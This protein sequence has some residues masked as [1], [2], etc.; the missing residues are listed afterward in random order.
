MKKLVSAINTSK[1]ETPNISILNGSDDIL[2]IDM[3]GHSDSS[4]L[5]ELINFHYIKTM[6]DF[7]KGAY[8]LMVLVVIPDPENKGEFILEDREIKMMA[9]F[10]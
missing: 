9:S 7:L 10:M 6:V 1:T 2:I 4:Q 5:K 8:F 3:P